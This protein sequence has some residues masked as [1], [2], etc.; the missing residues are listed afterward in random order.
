MV[1]VV[2]KSHL[3]HVYWVAHAELRYIL[4]KLHLETGKVKL[5]YKDLAQSHTTMCDRAEVNI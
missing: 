5:K 1:L 2:P 4:A 3:I